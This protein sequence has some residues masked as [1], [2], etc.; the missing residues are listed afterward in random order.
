MVL[1]DKGPLGILPR[2][3]LRKML[4]EDGEFKDRTFYGV[5]MKNADEARSFRRGTA[6]A[7]LASVALAAY[8]G[9]IV[10]RL[11]QTT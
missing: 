11:P 4:F 6:S 3:P 7:V 8:L 9:A 2:G 10:E 5:M 1:S